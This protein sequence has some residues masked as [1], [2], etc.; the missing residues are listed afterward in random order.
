[1][2]HGRHRQLGDGHLNEATG[3][4]TVTNTGGAGRRRA[5]H[6]A[7]GDHRERC[8][9]RP[10]LRRPAVRLDVG[11]PGG[12]RWSSPSTWRPTI[13]SANAATSTVGCAVHHAPSTPPVSPTPAITETGALPAGITFTDNGDG[14]AT[15]AGTPAAGTGGSYPLTITATN[16]S[17]TATQAFTL[18]NAQAPTVTSR[19]D[20]HLLHRGPGHL[21]GD[22]HRLPGGHHHRDRHPSRRPHLHR[23]R[24][25][26]RPPS[27]GPP[28]RRPGSFPVAV[29]ATNSTG[30]TATLALDHH[31]GGVRPADH[32]QWGHRLLHPGPGRR[33][34][35]DHH[36]G[37]R[38]PRS[39]RPGRSR[40]G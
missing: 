16:A 33:L 8:R 9:L 37:P 29:S 20:G 6:H 4:V 22:H 2:G 21:H 36:R 39:P 27:P 3:A 5:G 24:V 26:A 30:S 11:R 13:I 7:A 25:T 19:T 17:G 15:L 23:Q 12:R 18:T 32:H 28:R 31:R 34:R 40:P 1:M 10:V 35:R 14:T 38:S